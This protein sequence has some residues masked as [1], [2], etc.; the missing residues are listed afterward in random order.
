M[1]YV[2]KD[3][4]LKTLLMQEA[5]KARGL[6]TGECDNW[7][8]PRTKDAYD[9][10]LAGIAP[11]APSEDNLYRDISQEGIEFIK[12]FEGLFLKAYKCPAGVW[13]IG[14][15]HT[16]LEHKDGTVFAGRTITEAEAESL[17][18]R[19]MDY[20]EGR[21]SK[22][23]SVPVNDDE[24]AALV[25]FDFNTGGLADSTLRRKLN[26][27][28]RAGAAEQFLRWNKAGGKTLAGLTRRR[29]SERNLFLG[30]RPAIIK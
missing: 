1:I 11:Q 9:A 13:T 3:P 28:D 4:S 8:G 25:S 5:L 14:Y 19:D 6:Y 21:V 27:G 30:I 24:F 23:I 12:H 22:L 17:L 7:P 16:G 29:K 10:F 26:A 20:F 2:E 18:R 15:G